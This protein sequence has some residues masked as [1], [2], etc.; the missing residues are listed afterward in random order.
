[1][2]VGNVTAVLADI[3]SSKPWSHT[4]A[5]AGGSAYQGQTGTTLG[6][7]A[8]LTNN[9]AAGAGAVQTNTTAALGSGYGGQFTAQPTLA[10][11][12]DG[13]LSSYQVPLGTAT[14]PGKTLYVT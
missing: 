13:I 8:L 4:L 10:I 9:L 1:M 6:T 7:T 14:I 11:G 2:R 12:T 5:G 3:A